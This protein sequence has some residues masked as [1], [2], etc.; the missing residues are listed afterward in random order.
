MRRESALIKRVMFAVI[1]TGGKQY[2]VKEGDR[3]KVEKLLAEEGGSYTFD[4]ILLFDDGKNTKVG[5][6]YLGNARVEARVL[7]QK[8]HKKVIVF[9]YHQKT[10]YKKKKGHRQEFTELEVTKISG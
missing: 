5:T 3:I 10:R 9:R 6:P 2:K 8:R 4:K 7:G 1:E